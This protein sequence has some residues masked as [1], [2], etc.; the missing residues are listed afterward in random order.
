MYDRED[1]IDHSHDLG[2]G[3][4]DTTKRKPYPLHYPLLV[5]LLSLIAFVLYPFQ[6]IVV[7]VAGLVIYDM[8]RKGVNVL[9]PRLLT[10]AAIVISLAAFSVG[11][12]GIDMIDE[13][14]ELPVFAEQ[15]ACDD[16]SLNIY[17]ACYNETAG[18][19][20][21]LL[22]PSIEIHELIIQV[23]GSEDIFVYTREGRVRSRRSVDILTA[24]NESVYGDPLEL[25]ILSAIRV[26]EKVTECYAAEKTVEV[27]VCG[28]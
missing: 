18:T 1:K 19:L 25:S 17:D 4:V 26:E 5:L 14:R 22:V 15:V 11:L 12:S 20:S 9:L 27:M 16:L 6:L 23:I 13:L 24:Y 8:K 2:I 7:L 10:I 21:A 3:Y 28:Q